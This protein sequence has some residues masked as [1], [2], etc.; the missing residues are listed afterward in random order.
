MKIFTAIF[1]AGFVAASASA[2][3]YSIP[4]RQAK[5]AVAKE[6]QHQHAIN[7]QGSPTGQP[8]TPP[9]A[10]NPPANPALEATLQN[11]ASLRAD[12]EKFDSNPTNKLPLLNDLAA[13]AQGAKASAAS[14]S[15]LAD[16]LTTAVAGKKK[17]HAQHQKLAQSVHAIFNSAHLAPAQQQQML[18]GVQKILL[19]GGV[20][21]EDTAK[22]IGDLK[23]IATETK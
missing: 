11:I 13:A 4:I 6:E 15:K 20:S 3:N 7:N 17:L 12:F 8:A 9:P 1:C 16:S 18:D 23:T 19:D 10:N 22:V 2:Q 21:P 14:I 5:N